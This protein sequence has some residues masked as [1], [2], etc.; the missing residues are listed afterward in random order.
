MSWSEVM[1]IEP[2]PARAITRE[3]ILKARAERILA[4]KSIFIGLAE[5]VAIANPISYLKLSDVGQSEKNRR[6]T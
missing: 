1:D 2:G 3:D 6:K 4:E 5:K